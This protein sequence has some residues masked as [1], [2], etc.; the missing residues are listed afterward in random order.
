[1]NDFCIVLEYY[2]Q[3]QKRRDYADLFAELP[4]D[5][6]FSSAA[7][8]YLLEETDHVMHD[9]GSGRRV[10]KF[11]KIVVVSDNMMVSSQVFAHIYSHGFSICDSHIS[12]VKSTSNHAMVGHATAEGHTSHYP[13]NRAAL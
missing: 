2:E 8:L 9:D 10:S 1:M 5:H 3:G 6:S 4:H 11:D 7:L 13:R 12:F